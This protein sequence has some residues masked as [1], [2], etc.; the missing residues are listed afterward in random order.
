MYDWEMRGKRR[1][2]QI[3]TETDPNM[4]PEGNNKTLSD[5]D[6]IRVE[7]SPV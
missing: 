1:Q 2:H 7:E 6:G 3:S 4:M 5:V